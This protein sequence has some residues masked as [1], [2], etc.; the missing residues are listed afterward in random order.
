MH[1]QDL[2]GAGDAGNRHNIVD[3]IEIE[4]FVECR[5]GRVRRAAL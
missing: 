4:L 1:Y 3:Q 5:V 2:C